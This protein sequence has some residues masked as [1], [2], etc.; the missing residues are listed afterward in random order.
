MVPMFFTLTFPVSAAP[1]ESE[2]QRA[3][4]SLL[5]RLKYRQRL[6]CYGWVLQRQ[7]NESLHFH[8]IAHLVYF[9]DLALWR[10]LIVKSGFGVQNRLVVAADRHA[11]Y[12]AKY[13]SRRNGLAVLAPLRRAYGFSADFP[14]ARVLTER[15]ELAERFGVVRD[16]ACS[17]TPSYTL[18]S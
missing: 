17:W 13:I 2:A 10:D 15:A 12:I 7:K 16:D 6:G 9:S 18:R 4:R 8:G 1:D 5:G 14:Q 3:L 11:G